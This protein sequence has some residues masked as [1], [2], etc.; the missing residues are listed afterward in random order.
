MKALLKEGLD[1]LFIVPWMVNDFHEI[2]RDLEKY[3]NKLSPMQQGF[4]TQSKM[5]ESFL[6]SCFPLIKSV[7]VANQKVRLALSEIS[8]KYCSFSED[9]AALEAELGLL[10][11]D[12][13]KLDND[14]HDAE[15]KL[16]ALLKK[17]R[18]NQGDIQ[19]CS[20]KMSEARK[21]LRATCNQ[22]NRLIDDLAKVEADVALAAS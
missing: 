11:D 12:E 18:I 17:K 13:T 9:L 14:I 20:F 3:G 22:K 2:T 16:F 4:L 1:D 21:S 5:F 7:G 6:L 15:D 19:H 10:V 8:S